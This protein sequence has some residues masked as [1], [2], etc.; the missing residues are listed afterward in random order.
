MRMTSGSLEA[1]MSVIG[2]KG[3]TEREVG[4]RPT[5]SASN[6]FDVVIRQSLARQSTPPVAKRG[7]PFSKPFQS[8]LPLRLNLR[9]SVSMPTAFEKLRPADSRPPGHGHGDE[10]EPNASP[11]IA[12]PILDSGA[13]RNSCDSAVS[14]QVA[15][16]MQYDRC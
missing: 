1:E 5:G 2:Q 14:Q 13:T 10:L 6:Q 15:Y 8:I 7:H 3:G 12:L 16:A 11:R 4:G 9:R